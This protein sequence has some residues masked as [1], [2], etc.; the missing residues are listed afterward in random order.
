[1]TRDEPRSP[2]GEAQQA[3]TPSEGAGDDE[4][5][6]RETKNAIDTTTWD[7][8]DDSPSCASASDGVDDTSRPCSSLEVALVRRLFSSGRTEDARSLLDDIKS[9]TD[10]VEEIELLLGELLLAEGKVSEATACFLGMLADN[11]SCVP[12]LK[13]VT[14][15]HKR[16]GDLQRAVQVRGRSPGLLA[17]SELTFALTRS[18]ACCRVL[19]KRGL[20]ACDCPQTVRDAGGAQAAR[21]G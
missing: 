10:A 13:A 18:P 3:S 9:S 6:R 20:L 7:D 5:A 15:L 14:Q 11:P 12:A 4:I 1:M 17:C 2:V 19:S 8:F 21:R 16:S